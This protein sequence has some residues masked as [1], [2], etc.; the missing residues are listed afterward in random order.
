M[1]H[2]V[3]TQSSKIINYYLPNYTKFP[4]MRF[5]RTLLFIG[6]VS[7]FFNACSPVKDLGPDEYLLNKNI[8]KSNKPELSQGAK[9]ILKQKPNR[10]ILGL[11]RFH[12]GVYNLA[13]KGKQTKFKK[14][15]KKTIGEEPVIL[16]PA[17]TLK[18]KSQLLQY[19]QRLRVRRYELL[20]INGIT[21]IQHLHT[22]I[23]DGWRQ[24]EG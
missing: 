14:W 15:V 16:E 11:F 8:L 21:Q 9:P 12:L 20:N 13:N 17:L 7:W 6:F 3:A 1:S 18:S 22:H 19:M 10:K 23:H 24:Q 2:S 5:I 4:N